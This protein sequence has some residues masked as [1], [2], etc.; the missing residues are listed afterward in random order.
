M[1]QMMEKKTL[2]NIKKCFA[3]PLLYLVISNFSTAKANVTKVDVNEVNCQKVVNIGAKDQLAIASYFKVPVSS[4]RWLGV[5][6]GLDQYYLKSCISI[7]DTLKGP[8]KCSS[9]HIYTDDG[10]RT[11]FN[12]IAP[13]GSVSNVVCYQ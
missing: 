7:F 5:Q 4:V 3:I 12:I 11:A 6:W 2:I 13:Y 8:V 10:G 1:A 9:T